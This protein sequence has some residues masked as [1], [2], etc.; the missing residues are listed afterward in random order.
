MFGAWLR[1]L[2]QFRNLTQLELAVRARTAQNYISEMERSNV[3]YPRPDI[4]QRLAVALDLP[5]PDLRNALLADVPP[6]LL[7]SVGFR[8]I[9][10]SPSEEPA[11]DLAVTPLP[12]LRLHPD[13]TARVLQWAGGGSRPLSPT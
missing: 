5:E 3:Q 4:L 6:P 9:P 10:A 12:G 13:E 11:P 7:T 8:A 2:R 1:K